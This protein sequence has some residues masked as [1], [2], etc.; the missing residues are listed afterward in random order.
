M[1]EICLSQIQSPIPPFS[2]LVLICSSSPLHIFQDPDLSNPFL[3]IL[4]RTAE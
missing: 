4:I 1:H 2:L 3:A